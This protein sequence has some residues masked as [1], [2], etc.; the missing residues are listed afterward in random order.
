MLVGCQARSTPSTE[1]FAAVKDS[2]QRSASRFATP[3]SPRHSV[4]KRSAE[5]FVCHTPRSR[6]SRLAFRNGWRWLMQCYWPTQLGSTCRPRP[7]P[8]GHRLVRL[9]M[10]AGS[11]PFSLTSDS[12][13][14]IGPRFFYQPATA[15][16]SGE[17]GCPD[18]RFGRGDRRRVGATPVRRS[19]ADAADPAQVARQRSRATVAGA[20]RYS[21]QQARASEV[22][23]YFQALPRLKT[24][25]VLGSSRL[26][27]G[28]P[29]A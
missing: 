17:R 25:Y 26:V 9:R 16:P 3:G 7:I 24:T 22:P 8:V 5:P 23:D 14:G 6:G 28:R 10:R 1:R 27:G 20:C 13:C 4:R 12:R 21:C 29:Q 19:G 11:S 18:P 15:F 2:S